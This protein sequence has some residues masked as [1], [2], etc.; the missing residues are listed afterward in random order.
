L[1][2]I[3][4]ILFFTTQILAILSGIYINRKKLKKFNSGIFLVVLLYFI[5]NIFVPYIDYSLHINSFYGYKFTDDHIIELKQ[6]Y[7]YS[8]GIFSLFLGYYYLNFP[9]HKGYNKITNQNYYL[10]GKIPKY[11]VLI[12]VILWILVFTNFWIS[13]ISIGNLFDL[14]NQNESDLLFSV[15]WKYPLIDMLSNCLPVCL[16]I[17]FKFS[18]KINWIWVVLFSL[19]LFISLLS[20]WRYRIILFF[21][22]LILDFIILNNWSFIKISIG[23]LF[24]SIALS[25]LTLNRMAI[26]KRQFH[27]IT[28]DLS[29]FDIEIFTTE[30]SNSR[31][32]KATNLYLNNHP[33]IEALGPGSWLVFLKNK[34]KSK[35]EFQNLQRPKPWILE[36][37]KAW[38]P[39][40][41]PWNPNPAVSQ[42]EEFFLTFGWIGLVIGMFVVGLWVSFLDLSVNDPVFQCF[43]I[44]GIA[45]LFQWTTRGFFLYQLQITIVCFFPFLLLWLAKPYLNNVAKRNKA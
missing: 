18:K 3:N 19:W 35:T 5:F 38:I 28:F 21:L 17:Q 33:D 30:F 10:Y 6:G 14:T 31:T 27:L 12:Q 25:W 20:G 32:F 42:M 36:V 16:F 39:P 34:L 44:V 8:I 26:A 45:L 7:I 9:L 4:I 41:W 40:G 29:R 22:F 13:G 11:M 1:V 37:T 43:K 24:L 2:I 15:L 23:A